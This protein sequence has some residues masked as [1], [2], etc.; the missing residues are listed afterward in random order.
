MDEGLETRHHRVEVMSRIIQATLEPLGFTPYVKRAQ[1]RLP[2][3]LALRLPDGFDDEGVRA[4]LRRREISVTG[5][6]GP[7]AGVIWRLGLMGESARIAP[8]AR[9]MRE[10]EDI[11]GVDGLDERYLAAVAAEGL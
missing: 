1:D 8:Y 3:V 2:T 6:L 10:L 4:E 11:L 5:G 7:T 9:L